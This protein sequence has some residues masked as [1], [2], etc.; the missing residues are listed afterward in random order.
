MRNNTAVI[1]GTLKADGTLE[2]DERPSLDPGR[3]EVRISP[4][5]T[6]AVSQPR[7]SLV[8]VLDEIHAAQRA[9][10]FVG[11]TREEIDDEIH[12][13]RAEWDEQQEAIERIQDQ[14]RR[15]TD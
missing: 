8:D 4:I 5:P 11:R 7:R 1:Q 2:L 12:Q 6:S 13:M 9:S 10:G 15:A 3:V 14:V